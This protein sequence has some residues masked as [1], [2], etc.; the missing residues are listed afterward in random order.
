MLNLKNINSENL[1]EFALY[2]I[3]LIQNKENNSMKNTDF[4]ESKNYLSQELEFFEKNTK[5]QDTRNYSF[6]HEIVTGTFKWN[7]TLDEYLELLI[8]KDF[9]KIPV[10]ILNILRITLYQI[11]FMDNIPPSA[12]INE[13]VKLAKK[14]GHPGTVKLTN[15]V[16]RNFLRRKNELDDLISKLPFNQK[17]SKL[18]S[19]P[20]WL[21]DY[22]S[23]SYPDIDLYKFSHS[24]TEPAPIFLRINTYKILPEEFKAKLNENNIDF[25]ETGIVEIIELKEKVNL[26]ELYGYKQ[27]Y[28]YVQDL[29][30]AIVSKVLEPEPGSFIIDFCAFPGGK[31]THLSE[32]MNNTGKILAIDSNKNREA[33]FLENKLR[34]GCS[35]IDI[36][37]QSA[38]DPLTIDK[39]A[40]KILVDPPC[41]GLGVIRRKPEIKFRKSLSDLKRLSQLQSEIILNASRYLKVNGELVYSTCTLS[42]LENEQVIERFLNENKN[43]KLKNFKLFNEE[44]ASFTLF[45]HKYRTDGFFIAKLVKTD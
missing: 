15:G 29:G 26:T 11:I 12:A 17:I 30:A 13:G 37:I 14:Y 16:L 33:R 20:L 21:V 7:I 24:M 27:G 6:I 9:H 19:L 22:W 5:L 4:S 23:E 42:P 43:F 39:P 32:L 3:I 31:T 25:L 35:N 40:D 45:P 1:R 28:W 44:K 8:K 34:L 38:T 41:S 2:L 10:I 18:C 36:L